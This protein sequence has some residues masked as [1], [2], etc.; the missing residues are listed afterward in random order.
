MTHLYRFSQELKPRIEL[1]SV[2]MGALHNHSSLHPYD[3]PLK[4]IGAGSRHMHFRLGQTE[5]GLWLALRENIQFEDSPMQK[6][7][8]EN[9]ARQMELYS[10]EGKRTSQFCIGVKV[11]SHNLEEL[12]DRYFLILEDFTQND[13]SD[14]LPGGSG[15]EWGMMGGGKVYYDFPDQINKVDFR[16]LDESC[17]IH[18]KP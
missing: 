1:S 13:K 12:S 9:Y 15:E 4:K 11:S 18:I 8:A 14:F 5:S 3:S 10:Q 17:V 6:I 2:L 7:I 16:F